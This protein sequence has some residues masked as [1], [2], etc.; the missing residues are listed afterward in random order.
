MG[1][2]TA[3][4]TVAIE[5]TLYFSATTDTSGQVERW[6]RTDG[7]ASGTQLVSGL[8]TSV[9]LVSGVRDA[10]AFRGA[11]W[12]ASGNG[13]WRHDGGAGPA[14]QVLQPDPTATFSEMF[15]ADASHLVFMTYSDTLV[16][17]VYRSD[18]TPAGTTQ[19]YS[20]TGAE[21]TY[22]VE[23]IGDH[24]FWLQRPSV[25]WPS[26]LRSDG[27][28]NGRVLLSSEVRS[29]ARFG[30]RMFFHR[31]IGGVDQLCVATTTSTT[32]QVVVNLTFTPW[33]IGVAGSRLVLLEDF[34][35]GRAHSTDGTA[36]LTALTFAPY[37]VGW[38][39]AGGFLCSL[40]PDAAGRSVLWRT[41]GTVAGT[42]PTVAFASN[43]LGALHSA[44][45]IG[46]GNRIFLNASDGVRGS[47]PWISAGTQGTTTL[48]ADLVPNGNSS[49]E[50]LG[51]AGERAYFVAF[52]PV[53]G[54]ELWSFELAAVGAAS[55]Q[56]F[57]VGCAGSNGITRLAVEGM[58]AIG[59]ALSLRL[60]RG[61]ANSL[62]LWLVGL[63][64][65]RL[66]V[67][68]GCEFLMTTVA[69]SDW[70]ITDAAG[71]A[72]TS[73]VVPSDPV[74]VGLPVVVQAACLDAL[75]PAGLGITGSEGVLL[76]LGG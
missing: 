8:P 57:G 49:P 9:G 72:T 53:R 66:S 60:E 48:L 17:R 2:R 50:L 32:A 31:S 24:T 21:A 46:A 45:R 22:S 34:Y 13:V 18:G 54:R 30:D 51:V 16:N 62:G 55:A 28:P 67:G 29:L 74:F 36:A 76:V 75:A 3:S 37:A 64:P 15:T 38:F 63:G 71:A 41:D 12:F 7:T 25:S 56:R 47:E 42:G 61:A 33:S 19:I 44:T 27:T 35:T 59:R 26:L 4:S 69:W 39:E 73:L 10:R 11:F 5:S 58:P 68:G 40:A 65:Q 23:Q 14:V 1:I 6:W 20:W 70:A 43:A 52:D